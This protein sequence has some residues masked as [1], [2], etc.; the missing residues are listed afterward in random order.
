MFGEREV[1]S[2]RYQPERV[3]NPPQESKIKTYF[4]YFVTL[5]GLGEIIFL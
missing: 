1:I 4:T 5:I 3:R 2:K